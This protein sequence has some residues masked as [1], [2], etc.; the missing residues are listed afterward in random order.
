MYSFRA[1]QE[2]GTIGVHWC[3]LYGWP[4]DSS[5]EQ[6]KEAQEAGDKPC[7][8]L[9]R[10]LLSLTTE[11]DESAKKA[12]KAIPTPQPPE[13]T[14]YQL[15]CDIF[16][17]S[18]LPETVLDRKIYIEC[19]LGPNPGENW[20]RTREVKLD[21]VSS[22]QWLTG[23]MAAG[24]S[25]K[26]TCKYPKLKKSNIYLESQVPDVFVRVMSYGYCIGYLRFPYNP[27]TKK[28]LA[29]AKIRWYSLKP[30]RFTGAVPE[31]CHPGYVQ[32]RVQ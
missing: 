17:V 31:G 32:L 6:R 3:N 10:V 12:K 22:M 4:I 15:R 5:E 25:I 24:G 11:P 16:Q 30:D 19:G 18:E 8:Y 1:L 21:G 28:D 20:G 23:G 27:K 14:T 9:G 29:Q 2:A 26:L 13:D 7:E